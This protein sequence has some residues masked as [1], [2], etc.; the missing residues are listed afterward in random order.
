MTY[1]PFV[2]DAPL[3]N[4][5]F[6]LLERGFDVECFHCTTD[7]QAIRDRVFDVIKASLPQ[8]RIDSVIVRK[9]RTAPK[10][11][12]DMRFYPE[13]LGYLLRYILHPC[14]TGKWSDLI[15]ITDRLPLNKKRQAIRKAIQQTLVKMLPNTVPYRILHHDSKSC[16]GLQI[17]D[18]CNWAIFRKWESGDQRSYAYIQRAIRSEFD[19]FRNGHTDWY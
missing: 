10:V 12:D 9:R 18:Y 1:R 13:M 8:L 14:N 2:A 19:V 11:R 7:K 4:L 3:T 5:K 16:C 15:V 17:A 6:D